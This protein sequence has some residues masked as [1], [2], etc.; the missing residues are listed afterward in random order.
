VPGDLT[1][2]GQVTLADLRLLLQ[3]LVGQATP[4]VE[5]KA[6]AA[7]ND[8]VTLADLRSLLHALE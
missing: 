5:A 2:D 3:M 6:L 7:P 8:Q 1:G 4:S